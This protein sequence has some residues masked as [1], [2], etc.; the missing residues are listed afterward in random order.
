MSRC[1][2][3]TAR[4][5]S[6]PARRAPRCCCRIPVPSPST[7]HAHGCDV[8][9]QPHR[10]ALAVWMACSLAAVGAATGH[11]S[12]RPARASVSNAD[13]R[14]CPA[15]GSLRLGNRQEAVAAARRAVPQ[16]VGEPAFQLRVAAPVADLH[17]AGDRYLRA[18]SRLDARLTWVVDLHP[19]G[20]QC[21]ACDS[22]LYMARFRHDGWRALN[23]FLW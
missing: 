17:Y 1:G 10:I 5:K 18:C 9:R 11:A 12:G 3:R 2:L 4:W 19:P 13:S 8:T 22:H 14:H 16:S 15:A 7:R 6:S 21:A 20:M 23:W